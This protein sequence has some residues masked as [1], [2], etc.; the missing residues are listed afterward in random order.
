VIEPDG[1]EVQQLAEKLLGV[2]ITEKVAE[3]EK[4]QLTAL[5]ATIQDIDVKLYN[6]RATG[7]AITQDPVVADYAVVERRVEIQKRTLQGRFI[8]VRIEAD[9]IT[10]FAL[11]RFE[12]EPDMSL[13]QSMLQQMAEE[14]KRKQEEKKRKQEEYAKLLERLKKKQKE[15]EQKWDESRVIDAVRRA[16]P[17][18]ADG[19]VVAG[20]EVYPVK[21]SQRGNGYYYSPQ[22]R[23]LSIGVPE[24]VLEK[25]V[26]TIILKDGKTVKIKNRKQGGHSKYVTLET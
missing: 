1:D 22:W 17:H 12:G 21:K 3:L 15:G 5:R 9:D 26:D 16:I 4:W 10:R 19:A 24:K 8:A 20:G 13:L 23:V 18:W 2:K 6:V 7:I 14:K 25:F 11:Y